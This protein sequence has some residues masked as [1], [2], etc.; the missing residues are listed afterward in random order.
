MSE[1]QADFFSHSGAQ[2]L[3]AR[4]RG[5][6]LARG[7]V[8]QTVVERCNPERRGDTNPYWVVR[9]TLINGRPRP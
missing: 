5:Y 7:H 8:V 9:S 2:C 6:W 3:A 4:I 1:T